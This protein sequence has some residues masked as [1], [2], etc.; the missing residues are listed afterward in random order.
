METLLLGDGGPLFRATEET[1]QRG[2]GADLG[3]LV[4]PSDDD[5][6]TALKGSPGAVAIVTRDDVLALRLALLVEALSPGIHLVVTIFDRT[7]AE[8]LRSG[9]PDCV[10]L[11]FAELAAPELAEPCLDPEISRGGP[12]RRAP[13]DWLVSIFRPVPRE[14]R[15]LIGGLV[16]LVAVIL[17]DIALLLVAT[18]LGVVDSIYGS[19]RTLT[20]VQAEP[21]V[22]EGPAWL[23]LASAAGM[24]LT[25]GF[26]ALFTAGLIQW[27]LDPRLTGIIGKRVVPRRDHVVVVGMGQVGLRLCTYLRERGVGVVAIELEPEASAVRFA[28]ARKIPVLIGHGEDRGLLERVFLP[29]ARALVAA[30]ADDLVNIEIAITADVVSPGKPV[31]LRAREGVLT[32]ETLEL[33][34]LGIVRDVHRTAAQAI[35]EACS[36]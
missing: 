35:T 3:S 5:V 27:L 16:G 30:T 11:S 8:R 22:S 10:V 32:R 25:L 2:P 4:D 29:R 1:L 9:V 12:S 21:A 6:R 26:A 19:V 13:F 14:A 31:V 23:K 20:T 24:L 18:D 36:V 33:F 28:R 15:L 34:G 7:V 17:A